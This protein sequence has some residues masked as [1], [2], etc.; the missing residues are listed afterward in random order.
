MLIPSIHDVEADIR[1]VALEI[2]IFFLPTN[3]TFRTRVALGNFRL[4]RLVN[5][6]NSRIREQPE[7]VC[8]F[9]AQIVICGLA[10]ERVCDSALT[11]W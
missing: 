8:N 11:K 7:L 9:F 1:F 5:A 6:S 4:V 10:V 2:V 3:E